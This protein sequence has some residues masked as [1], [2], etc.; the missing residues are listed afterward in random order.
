MNQPQT[1]DTFGAKATFAQTRRGFEKQVYNLAII[2]SV[3]L[4]VLVIAG[5]VLK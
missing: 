4:F 1:G 5:Q 2:S 3:A